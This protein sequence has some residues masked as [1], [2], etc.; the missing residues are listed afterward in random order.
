LVALF[1]TRHSLGQ[2]VTHSFEG[3]IVSV[4]GLSSDE[5]GAMTPVGEIDGIAAGDFFT[6]ALTYDLSA[7]VDEDA[8]DSR[9]LYFFDPAV[10]ETLSLSVEG[11]TV[12]TNPLLLSGADVGNDIVTELSAN[13]DEL[14]LFSPAPLFSAGWTS[15]FPVGVQLSATFR[16]GSGAALDSDALPAEFD[17][18][19]WDEAEVVLTAFQ[20]STPAGDFEEVRIIGRI[21]LPTVL[22]VVLDVHPGSK[23]NPVNIRSRGALPVG[24][25]STESSDATLIDPSTLLLGDPLLL[26]DGVAGASPWKWKVQD[27]NRDGLPD[28][29]LHFWTQDMVTSGVISP[30]TEMLGVMGLTFDGGEA[31]GVDAIK[32]IA[33]KAKAPPKPKK[34][35]K[36]K[37]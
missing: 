16:D 37:K 19:D 15:T 22:E 9:G 2:V 30:E 21:T 4:E 20:V 5:S 31:M 6:G 1:P 14:E 29:M 24:I 3:E 12:S 11:L 17:P 36:G 32:L 18:A 8:S 33:P 27:L 35:K 25:L 7:A 10:L 13:S 26:V 28:L 34:A 23:V